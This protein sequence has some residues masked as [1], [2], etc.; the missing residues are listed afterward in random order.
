MMRRL[1]PLLV[2]VALIVLGAPGVASAA[3]QDFT[4]NVVADDD[5]GSCDDVSLGD[6]TLREAIN[7]ANADAG[8]TISFDIDGAPPGSVQT[9]LPESPLPDVTAAVTIDGFTEPGASP[10][11]L[12]V[13]DDS[14]HLIELDGSK[15]GSGANG[16]TITGGGSTVRGLVVNR[17]SN[18]G[19]FLSDNGGNVVEGNFIGTDPAGAADRGN[20]SV[21]VQIFG[22]PDNTIGGTAPASRN[23]ISG[24]DSDGAVMGG[25]GAT[26]NTVQGNYI[27][28]DAAGTGAL[29]NSGHG[30]STGFDADNLIGGTAP[31][32]R[33]VISGNVGLGVFIFANAVRQ[34]VQGNYIGV[35]ATGS[36][37]IPNFNGV[38]IQTGSSNNLIGGTAAGAGN[39]ISG[40]TLRG[41]V[42]QVDTSRGNVVQGNLIGT[43]ASGTAALGNGFQGVYINGALNNTI[44]GTTA[45]SRNVISA[46]G[47]SGVLMEQGA[48]GNTVQ[49]NYIGTDITGGADLGNGGRGV[50][51]NGVSGNT[52]GGT[53]AGAGNV[54]SGNGLDGIQVFGAGATGNTIQ[55]NRIGTSH[56]GTDPLPNAEDGVRIDGAPSTLVGGAA[57][58]AGNVISGNSGSG[59]HVLGGSATGT[60]IQGNRIGTNAGGTGA[61]A[62]A[63]DGVRIDGA[64][65]NLVGGAAAGAGNVVS[66][67]RDSGV[68]VGGAAT[69]NLI[70]GNRI[71]TDATGTAALA[72]AQGV[73]VDGASSV[74]IGG[75]GG[76][77]NVI[78]GNVTYGVVIFG[79]GGD[80]LQ[81]NSIGTDASGTGDLGNGA[82][83]V[84]I[85]ESANNT[86]GGTAAGARNVIS[87]NGDAGV[88][89]AR[90][91]GNAVLGNFIG[92]D[93]AGTSD[94][95]NL[96]A[97]VSIG[98]AS[99]N[100]VG[101]TAAGAGNVIAFNDNP[102]VVVDFG[103]ASGNQVRGNS[104]HSNA[105]LGIDLE[106]AGVNPNDPD[107]GDV[108]VNGL[109]N[110]PDIAVANPSLGGTYVAGALDST[111]GTTFDLDVYSSPSCDSSGN[112]EGKVF[113]G[114]FQVTTDGA[115]D[116]SFVH[117]LAGPTA[118]G[119]A[120]TATA[121]A[122]DGSTSEFSGCRTATKPKADL[123]LTKED[124]PNIV[125]AGQTVTYTLTVTN[126]G[127]NAASGVGVSDPLPASA[128]FV[129][130]TPSQGSCS[131][132]STV[133]CDLGTI[134][135]DGSATVT[136]VAR[137]TTAGSI[138]NTAVV[139]ASEVDPNTADNTAS[140]TTIVK[141]NADGC[142]VVGSAGKDFLV[143]TPGDDVICGLGGNDTLLGKK[144]NDEIR[145]GDGNDTLKGAGGNDTLIGGSGN[146]TAV[147]GP[148]FD[149]VF[150]EVGAD[151]LNVKDGVHGNDSI[152]GGVDADFD[153]CKK[154]SGDVVTNC[155]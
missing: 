71:G 63:Q 76:A 34:S 99:D 113:L 111:P 45:A 68:Y 119:N 31:G 19:V 133:V 102:G 23:V 67:N 41:V 24:N 126:N 25:V 5:D 149:D 36:A 93:A 50:N 65:N 78:S 116:A 103:P 64:S 73:F 105:I 144:G 6:C 132:T 141:P 94:V 104:I 95:G 48:T 123:S 85:Q 89:I 131:G 33:N 7:A 151:F 75:L 106:P 11:T 86:V 16:L 128:A 42:I 127:P 47:G 4:V 32:A 55:G 39:V 70:R 46:S 154:D 145:G 18:V 58:G 130:A 26:G 10:N 118:V 38:L 138:V 66:G 152:D 101:G 82:A 90:S 120:V 148:G 143:G 27:G 69:G 61:L 122:P 112:G 20:A 54:I 22:V 81:G 80:L 17:F 107:D 109:Q 35:D 3:P 98:M 114:T 115:G 28:T 12:A 129:S 124:D 92:T 96:G 52:V 57:A 153:T 15:A 137:M 79:G 88:F 40:N 135:K 150:G 14:V 72:N 77:G 8:S 59:V 21:G 49:G 53:A 13:G 37:A 147:G 155:P 74:L 134:L 97:G 29:A 51:I 30:V 121:T 91:T 110:F 100:V 1:A 83:G 2:C 139:E 146:D 136:I 140:Q 43:D 117:Q 60:V 44:G 62:N 142:N 108:G 56:L 9:I 125:Q 84:S 87:G